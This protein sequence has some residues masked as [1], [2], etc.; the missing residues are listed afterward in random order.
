VL[1]ARAAWDGAAVATRLNI[2]IDVIDLCVEV[3]E[4]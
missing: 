1:R 2:V 3:M 4:L